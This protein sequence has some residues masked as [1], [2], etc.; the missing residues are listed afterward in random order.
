MARL[1]DVQY[2]NIAKPFRP[3][4]S[5]WYVRQ[6]Q[7]IYNRQRGQFVGIGFV[8]TLTRYVYPKQQT[9]NILILDE[10]LTNYF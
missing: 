4:G 9:N 8:L 1:P 5:G 10:Q 6:Q 3:K 2:E 7:R